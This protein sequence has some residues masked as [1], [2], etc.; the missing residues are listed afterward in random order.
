MSRRHF[1]LSVNKIPTQREKARCL[2]GVT[3]PRRGCHAGRGWDCAEDSL[4]AV[5]RRWPLKEDSVTVKFSC[6]GLERPSFP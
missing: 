1:P 6:L 3:V 2:E 5:P 4:Q